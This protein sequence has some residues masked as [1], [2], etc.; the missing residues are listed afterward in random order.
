VFN[1]PLTVN[2]HI[3]V[4]NENDFALCETEAAVNRTGFALPV[5][6]DN[7]QRKRGALFGCLG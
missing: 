5:L 3:I 4:D 6:L 7:P 1:E 2:H